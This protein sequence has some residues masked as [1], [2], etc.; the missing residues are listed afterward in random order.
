MRAIIFAKLL[1]SFML[2]L[3]ACTA[4]VER[5][6]GT[7]PGTPPPGT[8]VEIQQL[9][10][11]ILGLGPSVDPLEAKAAA[12]ASYRHTHE[13]AI[14]YQITDRALIHNIKVN[15]GLK[16]RGLCKHWAQDME[17][18][19]K[20]EDF[21]TLTLHRAIGTMVGFDHSTVIISQ[22]GDDMFEGIVVDPWREGGELTWIAT[23]E[24]KRWG[25]R[26]QFEVLDP[27]VAETARVRGHDSI[28]FVP[29][30]GEVPRCL[31]L[32]GEDSFKA[33]TD[34]LTGCLDR[35]SE[36]PQASDIE[37]LLPQTDA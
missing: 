19:L 37:D 35:P 29:E 18:R 5:V 8:E 36:L 27:I 17:K 20:E 33:S 6:Q 10:D 16:P 28:V 34:D 22:K 11:A 30:G 25:W 7:L 31:V 14:E 2:L 1:L 13:L 15:A 21:Q 9:A 4:Q 12:R 32:T 26:P 23:E 24:D 3:G